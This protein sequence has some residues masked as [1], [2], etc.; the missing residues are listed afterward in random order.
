MKRLFIAGAALRMSFA[1]VAGA[2]D[3]PAEY[4]QVLAALGKQIV[5]TQGEQNGAVYKIVVASGCSAAIGVCFG[6][7]PARQAARLDPI[8]AWRFE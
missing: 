1:P 3:I 2:P 8:E 5:G 4:Q 7:C 6:Y